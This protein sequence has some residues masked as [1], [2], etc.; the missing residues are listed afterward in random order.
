MDSNYVDLWTLARDLVM[1]IM[2]EC[3]KQLES[4][5]NLGMMEE[6][7]KQILRSCH[8]L[9]C[10]AD[11]RILLETPR[12]DHLYEIIV[13][14]YKE[15]C[16]VVKDIEYSSIAEIRKILQTHCEI[17]QNRNGGKGRKE[18]AGGSASLTAT[19][20]IFDSDP[21]SETDGFGDG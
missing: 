2:A 1:E 9:A 13:D 18:A 17:I 19:P 15:I 3:E 10:A 8:T 14:F 4:E 6:Y 21:D 5:S 20:S 12:I 7:E 11:K 16:R